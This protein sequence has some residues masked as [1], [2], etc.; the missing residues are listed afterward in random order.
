MKVA[1]KKTKKKDQEAI[2]Q[3]EEFKAASGVVVK[4]QGDDRQTPEYEIMHRQKV[5]TCDAYLNLMESDPSSDQCSELLVK[6]WLPD[7]QL[8]DISLDVLEDRVMLNAP[9]HR[10]NVA[11]PYKVK[12]DS[13]NAKWDKVKGLLTVAI[14]IN[15][16][17]K[18]YTKPE[19]AFMDRS[20]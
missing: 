20:R 2:W 8:K 5:G 14:P 10:L 3:P 18:Y 12:K 9:K 1:V 19:E 4:E 13:G 16:K 15:M 6:I 7:T 11:L 17:V